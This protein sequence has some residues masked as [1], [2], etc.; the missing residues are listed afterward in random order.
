MATYNIK[1]VKRHVVLFGKKNLRFDYCFNNIAIH[2]SICEKILGVLLDSNLS[3]REH[4]FQCVSKASRMCNLIHAN[5]KCIDML[6]LV[7]LYKC[8]ARPLL[9]YCS[10][11][12]YLIMCI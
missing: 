7:N 3:F 5:I 10:V 4:I 9:E 11:I 1:F 2:I 6:V 12:V 8:Y